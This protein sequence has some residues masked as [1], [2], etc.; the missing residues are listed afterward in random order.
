MGTRYLRVPQI[1][2]AEISGE[3]QR[4]PLTLPQKAEIYATEGTAVP[5]MQVDNS[6]CQSSFQNVARQGQENSKG[7]GA[8]G[9][10][11]PET[12]VTEHLHRYLRVTWWPPSATDPSPTL[13]G[14]WVG[15]IGPCE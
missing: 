6:H 5:E 8:P 3:Q 11:A 13:P 2:P 7:M 1:Q 15:S 14:G 10:S 4:G 9:Q 12:R